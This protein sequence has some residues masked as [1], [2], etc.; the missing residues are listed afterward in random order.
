MTARGRSLL[1][2][3]WENQVRFTSELPAASTGEEAR[4]TG[5]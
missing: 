1:A 5:R 2:P 4:R 3:C